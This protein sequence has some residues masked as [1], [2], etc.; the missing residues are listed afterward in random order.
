MRYA[1]IDSG[2]S[3]VLIDYELLKMEFLKQFF[4]DFENPDSSHFYEALLNLENYYRTQKGFEAII[5]RKALYFYDLGILY[6]NVNPNRKNYRWYLA[7]SRQLLL[8][9]S[10]STNDFIRNNSLYYL[11]N[12]DSE[13]I[14]AENN[15]NSDFFPQKKLLFPIN[16]KNVD[17]LYISIYRISPDDY[18]K[19][20]C[21]TDTT[22]F[23]YIQSK[24]VEYVGQQSFEVINPHDYQSHTNRSFY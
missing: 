14:S 15:F 12:I 20:S 21:S 19:I 2:K 8:P 16:Y 18:F 13:V 10:E 1:S 4:N 5:Y 17:S 3:E 7:K 22:Y 11:E 24:G 6:N 9:L 23:K